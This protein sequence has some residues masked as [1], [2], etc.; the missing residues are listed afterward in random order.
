MQALDDII[1][2]TAIGTTTTND[3]TTI[4]STTTTIV[5]AVMAADGWINFE[6]NKIPTR[7]GCCSRDAKAAGQDY[8][9]DNS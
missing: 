7:V 2:T 4:T 6:D 9:A 1:S 8:D 5:D 3:R